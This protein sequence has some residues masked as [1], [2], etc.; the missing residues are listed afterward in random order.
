MAA[1][2]VGHWAGA[3]GESDAEEWLLRS[4]EHLQV[5]GAQHDVRSITVLLDVQ[6]ALAG[7]AAAIERLHEVTRSPQVED[8]DIAQ[9]HL[10]LAHAAWAAGDVADAVTHAEA[11]TALIEAGAV[12]A[13]QA[14]I[15]FRVAAAVVHLRSIGLGRADDRSSELR[16]L[17]LLELAGQDGQNMLDMPVLGSYALGVAELA[18][19]RGRVADAR[20]LWSLGIRL[21]ANLALIFQLG[22][23]AT[24]AEVLGGDDDRDATLALWRDRPGPEAA[25]RVRELASGIL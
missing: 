6:R 14:R 20:E 25:A 8:M 24:L 22:L 7:E 5:V 9:A 23:G 1:Q 4:I 15:L 18:A 10:G 12:V 17:E 16:A 21:G 19:L 3:R 11:A 13:P 2:G